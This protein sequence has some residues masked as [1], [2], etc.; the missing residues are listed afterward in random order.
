MDTS[1]KVLLVDDEPHVT[2]ILS[3]I[4]SQSKLESVIASSGEEALHLLRNHRVDLMITDILMPG[5][6]GLELMEK[7]KAQFPALPIIVL[8]AHGDFYVAK[9][10]LNR[11]AFYFLTKPFNKATIIKVTEKA[12]RLPRLTS[13]KRCV[14][15]YATQVLRYRIPNET[16]MIPAISHQLMRACDDMGFS[17]KKVNFAVPLAV[18]ELVLNAIKHGNKFD[19]V[20][21]VKVEAEV[22]SARVTITVEDEGEGFDFA[23]LPDKFNE[24][25]L[26]AEEGR[27]IMMVRFYAED[28]QFENGGR[29]AVC[30]VANLPDI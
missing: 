27:G 10:A 14:I 20:K 16:M 13:E 7:I 28:L 21:T 12:L 15:P 24:E 9:E 30:R 29:R 19:P 8:T 2:E 1:L 17:G 18:D 3:R 4:L 23:S 26:M 22:S 25:S 5:M 6:N 11:G